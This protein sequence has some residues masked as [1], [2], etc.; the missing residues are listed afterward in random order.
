MKALLKLSVAGWV[1]AFAGQAALAQEA[2]AVPAEEVS[3]G[4][5]EV[6]VTAQRRQEN[7][8]NAAIAAS[9]IDGDALRDLAVSD[10]RA[11]TRIVPALQVSSANGPYS[12]FYLRGVGNYNGNALSEAAVAFNYD[13]VYIGRPSSTT[14]FFY[15]LER[16]EVLKGPQGT[17]YGR[18][19]TGGAIN[20]IPRAP[21][22]DFGAD[23][24]AE[25]GDYNAT[26]FDAAVNIPFSDTI[27]FRA[28]GLAVQHDGYMD[29]G[30]D[31]QDDY[32]AR[33]QLRILATPDLE[34]TIGFDYF[35]QSGHGIGSTPIDIGI[36]DRE[37]VSSAAGQA[38]YQTLPHT[39][40][41]RNFDPIPALQYQ[42]NEFWG[43]SATTTW[44]T[45]V[46]DFTLTPAYRR[47]ELL[48]LNTTVGFYIY[49]EEENEQTSVELR[50]AS[51]TTNPLQ[52]LLG[53][54]Y[55]NEETTTPRFLVN[56]QFNHFDQT[57]E[58]STESMAAFGRL[59]YEFTDAFRVTA[60]LRYTHEEKTFDGTLLSLNRICLAGLFSCPNSIAF[61]YT[62]DRIS[63]AYAPDGSVIPQFG[64]DGTIQV[65]NVVIS[66]EDA[67][68][69]RLTWRLGADFDI[70]ERNLVYASFE[71]GFKSGGFF[72]S[73]DSGV[74]EPE[75]MEAW[76]I[77]SKNRFLD[78]RLQ[79]NLEAYHWR[80]SDQQISHMG[81]DSQ[82][83]VIFP[84]EN[85]GR[86]TFQG[87]EFETRYLIAADT[88]IS[89]DVQYLDAEYNDFVYSVPNLGA[90]PISGCAIGPLAPDN[91]YSVDCSGFRPPQAPELT[92]NLGVSQTFPFASGASIVLDARTHYQSETLTS[93][94]F[95][96]EQYQDGYWSSDVLI[97]FNP[98]EQRWF[99]AAFVNNLED[100]TILG[101]T[102]QV[103]FTLAGDV[104]GILRPPRT[105]GVRA[106]V[107]F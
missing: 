13:G 3:S 8:Q 92:F 25:V 73:S 11:L 91:T 2:P 6:I 71:T 42:D 7:L 54:Y 103:P 84:T 9:A 94:E 29:D 89:A 31:D 55:Y 17:L 10:P 15:D 20:I 68:F 43:V 93:V 57:V 90:P 87:V 35:N 83:V 4:L 24:T 39:L 5:D 60:G 99:I 16:V 12:N 14:G 38:F 56:H 59:T 98:P 102:F 79:L 64:A 21:S 44:S 72:V 22:F 76:T 52:V 105:F 101:S 61:P 67:S 65:G 95:V 49:Q 32:G 104:V 107:H 77:G 96:P 100:K 26:R 78:N 28:A 80:Y 36:D 1:F 40:G 63:V 88:L 85:V 74:F 53:G 19:A 70:S 27:A 81:L 51:P 33:L 69:N 37:G 50:Y 82:G 97:T 66:D 47:A 75:L 23:L 58:A 46:G 86:A 34:T 30:T 18:N 45:A 106:G 62:T 48:N 41:G